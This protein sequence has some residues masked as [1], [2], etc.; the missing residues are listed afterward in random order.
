MGYSGGGGNELFR[1]GASASVS[2]GDWPGFLAAIQQA[3][4][5]FAQQPRETELCLM[6][7]ALAVRSLYSVEQERYSIKLAWERIASAFRHWR[8]I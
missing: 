7:Q 8:N 3:F 5:A 6:R 2:F 4:D 1:F